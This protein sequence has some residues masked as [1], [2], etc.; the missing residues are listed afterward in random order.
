[1]CVGVL[2]DHIPSDPTHMAAMS[3]VYR[4]L[5]DNGYNHDAEVVLEL[6]ETVDKVVMAAKTGK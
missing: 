3:E 6:S 2:A 1:M 5:R 4:Y